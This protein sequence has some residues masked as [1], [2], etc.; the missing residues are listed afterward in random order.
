[1]NTKCL[2]Q[3]N[4]HLGNVELPLRVI[5]TKFSEL[6]QRRTQKYM[7]MCKERCKLLV[8]FDVIKIDSL[9]LRSTTLSFQQNTVIEAKLALWH[10]T[11]C[12]TVRF[13]EAHHSNQLRQL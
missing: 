5:P 9:S 8:E 4:N 6:K 13:L 12:I 2:I 1:M 7:F 11:A 3:A 10:T